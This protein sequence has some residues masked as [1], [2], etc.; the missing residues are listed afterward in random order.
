MD[1]IS[2]LLGLAHAYLGWVSPNV[3]QQIES[4]RPGQCLILAT[5]G[6]VWRFVY[7]T[8]GN[9]YAEPLHEE[10]ERRIHLIVSGEG[11]SRIWT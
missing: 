5:P 7:P 9:A 3:T 2:E 10:T 4:L 6:S 8:Q 1:P 11:A